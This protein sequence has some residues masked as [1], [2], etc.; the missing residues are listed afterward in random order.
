[1]EKMKAL[2]ISVWG[3][4]MSALGIL[5]I[6]VVLLVLSNII[7]YGTGLAAAK[8]R[9]EEVNSYKSIRGIAKK[10]CMWL[11]VLVGFIVDQLLL[12]ASSTVGIV[13]PFTYLIACVVAIWLVC[14][15]IISILENISD[16]GVVL[17]PFLQP[18]VK[19]IKKQ[20][21]DKTTIE[22]EEK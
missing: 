4:L 17:P 2:V 19:N 8:Y 3:A 16:I 5:A 10:I 14:N 6:P 15:E 13:L 12:Y 11:L 22:R 9:E 18:I 20:V 7:D 21:E 1:M